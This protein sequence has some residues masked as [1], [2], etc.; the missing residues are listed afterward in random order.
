MFGVEEMYSILQITEPTCIKIKEILQEKDS[1]VQWKN[2]SQH[3][4]N[5]FK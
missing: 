5:M 4:E 2:T 3:F 1:T